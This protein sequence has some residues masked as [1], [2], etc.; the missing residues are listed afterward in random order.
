VSRKLKS[1][2][3]LVATLLVLACQALAQAAPVAP[4][5]THGDDGIAPLSLIEVLKSSQYNEAPLPFV[6]RDG[7]E[8]SLWLFVTTSE[9]LGSGDS[10]QLYQTNLV[11]VA[12]GGQALLSEVPLPGSAALLG[13]GL[14]ALALWFRGRRP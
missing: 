14:A 2:P 3:R 11:S 8:A 12:T 1:V 13:A 7:V 10:L 5:P 9:A 6:P 4:Q